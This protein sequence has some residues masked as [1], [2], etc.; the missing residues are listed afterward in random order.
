MPTHDPMMQVSRQ[1]TSPVSLFDTSTRAK[2]AAVA[3]DRIPQRY[4]QILDELRRHGPQT[5]FEIASKLGVFDHQISGRFTELKAQGLIESTGQTRRKP[6]TGC[7]C[8]VYQLKAEIPAALMA[9]A[10]GYPPELTLDGERWQRELADLPMDPCSAG[11]TG[12]SPVS[13]APAAPS[14]LRRSVAPS[15]PSSLPGCTYSR[16]VD[17]G[18]PGHRQRIQ[19]V[20]LRCPN[21]GAPLKHVGQTTRDG[22]T[23]KQFS[24]GGK[25]CRSILEPAF[26]RPTGASD[27]LA[28]VQRTY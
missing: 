1:D 19:V 7:E 28:L 20:F 16:R 12:V 18:Q 22:R 4:A 14:S 23:I 2:A 5:L 15:L 25:D 11:G 24:C 17:P 13:P 8:E 26:A 27:Q 6:A 10:L 9:D 21:C 3:I